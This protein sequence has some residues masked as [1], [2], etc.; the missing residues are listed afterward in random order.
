MFKEVHAFSGQG[1]K[2]TIQELRHENAHEEGRQ[3]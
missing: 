1:H 2:N 3:G